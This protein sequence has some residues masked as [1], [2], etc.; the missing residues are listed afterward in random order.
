LQTIIYRTDIETEIAM[1][2]SG[3]RSNL[4]CSEFKTQPHILKNKEE[5]DYKRHNAN[6]MNEGFDWKL[7]LK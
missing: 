5:M 1:A 6:V 3:V 7:S 2:D 4:F